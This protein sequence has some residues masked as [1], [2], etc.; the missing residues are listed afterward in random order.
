MHLIISHLGHDKVVELLLEKGL[1]VN[2]KD[3]D[4]NTPLQIATIQGIRNFLIC[5]MRI[6][7]IFKI[8]HLILNEKISN[9]DKVNVVNVLLNHGADIN[10]KNNLNKTAIMLAADGGVLTIIFFL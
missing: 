4:G 1:D 10:A 5:I 2:S 6:C 3:V 7:L 8:L 9:L